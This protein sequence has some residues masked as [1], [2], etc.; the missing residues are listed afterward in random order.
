[1]H[2][3]R[4]RFRNP[5]KVNRHAWKVSVAVA[6]KGQ[7]QV[8]ENRQTTKSPMQV[9]EGKWQSLWLVQL[10]RPQ[11]FQNRGGDFRRVP[12]LVGGGKEPIGVNHRG[13]SDSSGQH[14]PRTHGTGLG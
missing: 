12:G 11:S 14:P 3:R 8:W 1:M 9:Y 10:E 5:C 4:D 7:K 2:F 13:L 6:N